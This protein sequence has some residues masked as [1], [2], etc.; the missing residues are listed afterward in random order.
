MI[1]CIPLLEKGYS[2]YSLLVKGKL[3]K[4]RTELHPTRQTGII[5]S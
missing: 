2:G 1:R 3:I 4:S 5:K